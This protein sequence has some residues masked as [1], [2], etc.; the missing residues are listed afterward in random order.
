MQ[1]VS[2]FH[3]LE[4]ESIESA[5][6]LFLGRLTNDSLRSIFFLH[7]KTLTAG[8]AEVLK[9]PDAQKIRFFFP[10]NLGI[11]EF[12]FVNEFK[13]YCANHWARNFFLFV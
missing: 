9:N 5:L 11:F 6:N 3:L 7:R 10:E 4:A 12:L 1:F 2:F 13:V 8:A